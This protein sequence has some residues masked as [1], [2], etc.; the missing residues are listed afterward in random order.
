MIIFINLVFKYLIEIY[1]Y[2]KNIICYFK[3]IKKI[4]VI[5]NYILITSFI[6][7]NCL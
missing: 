4:I 2:E 6:L 7:Y 1:L 5:D 3:V